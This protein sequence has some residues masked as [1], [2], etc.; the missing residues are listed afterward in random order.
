MRTQQSALAVWL[1]RISYWL[2][3]AKA[4]LQSSRSG[5]RN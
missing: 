4:I 5:G 3:A 2:T 1:A